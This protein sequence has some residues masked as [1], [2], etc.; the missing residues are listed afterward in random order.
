MIEESWNLIIVMPVFAGALY[1]LAIS[2]FD[3]DYDERLYGICRYRII[4]EKGSISD[5][6][7]IQAKPLLPFIFLFWKGAAYSSFIYKIDGETYMCDNAFQSKEDAD[8]Q[9][10]ILKN[11]KEFKK[12]FVFKKIEIC[13]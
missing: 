8:H 13:S 12:L 5:V 3:D 6:Y 7:F 10:K 9:V 1:L 4:K 11:R 2:F